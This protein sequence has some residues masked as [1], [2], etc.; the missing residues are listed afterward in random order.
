MAA[1]DH[2]NFMRSM[3]TWRFCHFIE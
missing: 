2:Y 1:T 3:T